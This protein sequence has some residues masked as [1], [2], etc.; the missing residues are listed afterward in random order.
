MAE[1]RNPNLQSS[2]AGGSGG[3]GGDMRSM[4]TLTLLALVV[5]VGVEYFKPKP[6]TP[7]PA[8]QNQQ[9]QA[10]AQPA[11]PGQ[12]QPAA[13]TASAP[14]STPAIAAA[15]ETETTI[16]NERYKITFSNRGAQVK[17]WLLKDYTDTAGKPL[18]MV[19]PQ[20]AA[21][22]GFP[23]S[24]FTYDQGLTAQLNQALYQVT[25]SGAQP[26]VTGHAQVPETNA[27]TFHYAADGLD[28]VK[29]VRF[30][31]TYVITVEAQV[32]RNGVPVRV[33]VA[34]PAGLGDM[35]EFAASAARRA[36]LHLCFIALCLVDRRQTG[37]RLRPRRSA[38][39]PR[40]ISPTN[41]RSITDLYFASVFD[42]RGP[43]HAL[44]WL[45]CT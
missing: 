38:A 37:L 8:A 7:T 42:A 4:L 16:E 33:L 24:L 10:P 35:E 36:G 18:D 13:A 45:R 25:A 11:L 14:S 15:L 26:S 2:G 40:S 21:R 9:S 28:V 17:R 19:Q 32:R 27:L 23:L 43:P 5:L 22:F 34:W 3:S 29:T 41:T 6:A 30:D 44:R 39:T 20:A 1:I 12:P 31:A